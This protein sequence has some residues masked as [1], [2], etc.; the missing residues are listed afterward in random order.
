M[1]EYISVSNR[2]KLEVLFD[3][4]EAKIS[5]EPEHWISGPDGGASYCLECCEKEIEKLSRENPGEDYCVDGGWCIEGD[6]T[7][8]CEICQKLLVNTL[9]DYGCESE[10]EHFL[11]QGFDAESNDDCRAMSEV[12]SS[13]GWEPICQNYKNDMEKKED[14]NYFEDLHKL[15]KTILDSPPPNQ[16]P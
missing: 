13:R 15:C 6:F 2:E 3:A 16:K 12:I 10:V 7:P 9:T 5:S 8:F 11:E 1:N 14:L 4:G